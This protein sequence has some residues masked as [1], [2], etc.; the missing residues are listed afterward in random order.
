MKYATYHEAIDIRQLRNEFPVGQAFTE[1][2]QGMGLDELRDHQNR[3][4]VRQLQRAWQL[5]FYQRLWGR[6]GVRPEVSVAATTCC[7]GG[8]TSRAL[9]IYT[10]TP[11]RSTHGIQQLIPPSI[12]PLPAR[13]PGGRARW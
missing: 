7:F 10:Q 5:P 13:G 9:V 4:F 3:L 12:H 1:R 11:S 2:Y 6:A 8:D